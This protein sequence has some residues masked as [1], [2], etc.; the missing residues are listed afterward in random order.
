MQT[1]TLRLR[2]HRPTQ[3]KINRYRELVA[4]TTTFANN[5]IAAGRPKGLTSRT[6]REYL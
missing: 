1:I 5:L 6:A 4:R 2:L 3:A